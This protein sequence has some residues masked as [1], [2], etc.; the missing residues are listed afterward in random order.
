[1]GDDI[2]AERR[3]QV[4]R[5]RDEYKAEAER[6]MVHAL[7]DLRERV[8][9]AVSD[10]SL[11]E[12]A[13]GPGEDFSRNVLAQIIQEWIDRYVCPLIQQ[14]E[15]AFLTEVGMPPEWSPPSNGST[16]GVRG[17][18]RTTDVLKGL[19]APMG[20]GVGAA[21]LIVAITTTTHFLVFTTVV[22]AWPLLIVGL[23]LAGVAI[24]FGGGSLARL[25]TRLVLRLEHQV[26]PRLREGLV[27]AGVDGRPSV[28]AE[29]QGAI[30]QVAD[31]A[32]TNLSCEAPP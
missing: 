6:V 3:C 30:D 10:L 27:G 19:A 32:L 2:H 26:E 22:V 16:P 5:W 12:L 14:A 4:Y 11:R 20:V 24:L 17:E 31:Q 21:S 7:P 28:L 25:R 29:L 15:T 8:R 18:L 1:M 13:L 23:S 9:R